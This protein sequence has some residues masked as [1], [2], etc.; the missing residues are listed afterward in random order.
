MAV[1]KVAG[2]A[3]DLKYATA[4]LRAK[5][6]PRCE[7][8]SIAGARG[9]PV[10]KA[11]IMLSVTAVAS[12]ASGSGKNMRAPARSASS[13]EINHGMKATT[14]VGQRIQASPTP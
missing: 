14:I 8:I 3:A 4:Q 13:A 12:D 11:T 6:R 1:A 9:P 7:R 2:K 10:I 5:S